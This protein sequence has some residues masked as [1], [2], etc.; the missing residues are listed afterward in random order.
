MNE[1]K[2]IRRLS[3]VG[4]CGNIALA[5]LKM[6]A[7]I[8]G[9]SAAMI[10][11]A[12]HSLADVLATLVACIGV[13]ISKKAPDRG[14][15]YGHERIECVA[16]GLLGLILLAT[17]LAI[18]A[19][20]AE[21]IAAG[22]YDE[23]ATPS[24]PALIAAAVS[25]AVKECMFWY[26]RHYAKKLGSSAFMA[27]AWHHRSD[28]L[29]ALGS[30]IGIG[31]AMLGAPVMEPAAC[32]VIC[33]FILKVAF[34]T[35]RDAAGKLVDSSCGEKY[36]AALDSFISGQE[37]VER[38][39]ALRTRRFGSR[40]CVDAEIAVDGSLSL[41]QAHGIA[42]SVH[43]AVESEYPDVKHIMIHENPAGE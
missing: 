40:V 29:S 21:K 27:D 43:A 12:V 28:A 6:C 13:L 25:I 30:L 38:I 35:L 14:H 23:L 11:D 32:V 7:G 17:G 26:T 3:A 20:G 8:L 5:A 1:K 2:I 9:R 37:G 34:D 16:S 33:F 41:A 18:G 4:I 22:H 39:D 42:E 24:A 36:E 31:G 10:S 19:G 15:P